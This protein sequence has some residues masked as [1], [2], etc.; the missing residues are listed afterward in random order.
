M[1]S[2][3]DVVWV[4]G[5]DGA[6]TVINKHSHETVKR[7]DTRAGKIRYLGYFNKQVWCCTWDMTI[8][9]YTEVKIISFLCS[10]I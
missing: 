1:L 9:V 8:K 7:I 4:A 3:G 6:I 10:Y 2:I 5:D